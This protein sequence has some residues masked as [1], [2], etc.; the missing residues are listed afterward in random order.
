MKQKRHEVII[1]FYVLG[2][3][4]IMVAIA[5]IQSMSSAQSPFA[6]CKYS[7]C[8]VQCATLPLQCR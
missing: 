7:V 5:Q 8:L 1:V 2:T 3:L 6:D 4:K